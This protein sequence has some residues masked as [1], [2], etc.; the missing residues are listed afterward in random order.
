MK[1][2][3]LV[4]ASIALLLIVLI[5]IPALRAEIHWQWAERKD[6]LTAY[7]SYVEARPRGR[8]I[9]EARARYDEFSWQ[10]ALADGTVKGFQQYAG[11]HSEG[12]YLAE[13]GRLID[14]IRWEEAYRTDT[15]SS[16][17]DYLKLQPK[18][19]YADEALSRIDEMRWREALSENSVQDYETYLRYQTEG[20]Y[21]EEAQFKIAEVP[22]TIKAYLGYI[23]R[24]PDG[25][26][27]AEAEQRAKGLLTDMA[28]YE[29]ALE[30]DTEAAIRA[31][32][33]G[34]PGH[35]KEADARRVLDGIIERTAYEAA[36]KVGKGDRSDA[37]R[38]LSGFI[39]DYP[40]S[41]YNGE[42]I[43][44]IWN[45]LQG[46][47]PADE[48]TCS[49][50]LG[51]L[52]SALPRAI[53]QEKHFLVAFAPRRVAGDDSWRWRTDFYELA[54]QEC[55]IERMNPYITKPNGDMWSWKESYYS[56]LSP[57]IMLGPYGH[58]YHDW[59]CW[60]EGGFRGSS[61]T[62]DFKLVKSYTTFVSR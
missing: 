31:F 6:E 4:V 30:E 5:S 27:V 33:D 13:A 44:Q 39:K 47:H 23:N 15:I 22:D 59:T 58:Q 53:A 19:L 41:K 48:Y 3:L 25:K 26:Y 7:Q 49:T 11:T 40:K 17:L 10:A 2:I 50:S 36:I 28:V 46:K 21:R 35:Q 38:I 14:N 55:T 34:Y 12:A 1:K 9:A 32:L 62:L 54:G 51:T 43:E 20:K 42:I 57:P 56:D 29:K 45:Y 60:D 52:R 8:H 24:Y 61:V 18:G 16:Y 37:I